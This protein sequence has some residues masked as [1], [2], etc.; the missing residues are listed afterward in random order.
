MPQ[1]T[2]IIIL[3][4]ISTSSFGQTN[5]MK[6]NCPANQFSSYTNPDTIFHFRS[7]NS[8][9]L[10]GSKDTETVKGKTFYTEFVLAVCG[11]KSV[12]DF[13]GAIDNYKLLLK[14]DTLFVEQLKMLPIGKNFNYIQSVWMIDKLFFINNKVVR[15]SSPNKN[16]RKYNHKEIEFVLNEYQT[17]K[18]KN[19][20][21]GEYIFDKLFIATISGSPEARKYFINFKSKFSHLGDHFDEEF[22]IGQEMLKQW[23]AR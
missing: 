20:E 4:F 13:W 16:I 21:K 17:I 10:C 8:I 18:T 9:V 3:L 6:C 14:N 7:G 2:T 23:D 19:S 22:D 12:I 5:R 15:K 11:Q 1:F